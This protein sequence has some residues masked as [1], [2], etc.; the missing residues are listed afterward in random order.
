VATSDELP[1]HLKQA[2]TFGADA[3]AGV[4]WHDSETRLDSERQTPRRAGS[5][6]KPS[7]A[8]ALAGGPTRDLYAEALLERMEAQRS[9]RAF[10]GTQRNQV[11]AAAGALG[12]TRRQSAE[13]DPFPGLRIGTVS[14]T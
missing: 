10:C 7:S 1:E 11:Q 12:V 5:T 6:G 2:R 3:G 13:Q 4:D 8:S 14:Q 9:G